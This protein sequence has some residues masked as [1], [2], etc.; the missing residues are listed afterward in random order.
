MARQH[1]AAIAANWD[2][3]QKLDRDVER[4]AAN[5]F[6]R[7]DFRR[8]FEQRPSTNAVLD[9][10]AHAGQALDEAR[11]LAR[12]AGLDVTQQVIQRSAVFV[13]SAIETVV[14]PLEVHAGGVLQGPVPSYPVPQPANGGV[15]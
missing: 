5:R 8:R 14:Q 13:A 2:R 10:L 3:E 12:A 9:L 1:E 4:E 11:A 7:H 15:R 6:L